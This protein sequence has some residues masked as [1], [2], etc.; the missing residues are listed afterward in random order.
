MIQ[1]SEYL[2]SKTIFDI[3]SLTGYA[4]FDSDICDAL[5]TVFGIKYNKMYL[6]DSDDTV[7]HEVV[8]DTVLLNNAKYN[9]IFGAMTLDP[10]LEFSETKTNTGTQTYTATGTQTHETTPQTVTT[11]D[12]SKNT[13]NNA[14]L[15]VIDRTESSSTGSDTVERTDDLTNERTDDLSETREG[16]R[17]IFDNVERL[18][19]F[20]DMELYDQII[21][22]VMKAVCYPIYNIDDLAF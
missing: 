2:K 7:I 13:A 20:V 19:H 11:V 3:T 10:T 4:Y 5:N 15:R 18:L 16:Y 21:K 14:T 17:N 1:V 9:D 12:A 8:A 6:I 22:D